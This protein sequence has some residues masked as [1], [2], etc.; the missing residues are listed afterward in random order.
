VPRSW[1]SLSDLMVAGKTVEAV[2]P[3]CRGKVTLP[4]EVWWFESRGI[5]MPQGQCHRCGVTWQW[6][7]DRNP[8]TGATSVRSG[9]TGKINVWYCDRELT[10]AEAPRIVEVGTNE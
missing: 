1:Q 9:D 3:R 7:G 4:C 2:C 6:H 8:V 10:D 5:Y